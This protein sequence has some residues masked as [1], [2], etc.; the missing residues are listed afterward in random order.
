MSI[1]Y[2]TDSVSFMYPALGGLIY[3]LSAVAKAPVQIDVLRTALEGL[4]PRFPIMCSHLERTFFGYRHI[5]ATDFDVITAG[6]PFFQKPDLFDT[7]KPAFRM[8]VRGCP[9]QWMYITAT[10]TAAPVCDF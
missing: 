8:Y 9:S 5:P 4:Q 3:R 7:Q 1:H 10:A 2:E 6:E